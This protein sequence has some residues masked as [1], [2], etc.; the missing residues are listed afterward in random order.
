VSS[1]STRCTVKKTLQIVRET[2]NE[3]IVQVK[4]NQ[5]N[6]VKDLE[7]IVATRAPVAV[8][9]SCD[10]ARNRRE[11]RHVHVY[12]TAAALKG[13]E[14]ETLVAAM[15]CVHRQTLTRSAATGLWTRREEASFYI[16]SVMLPAETFAHAIRGHWGVENKNHWV[17]D[18]TLSEDAS[19][20]RINPGIM[21]R[22]RSQALNIARA[23][24]I[25]NIAAALWNAAIDPKLTL[26]YK[27]L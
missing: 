6:L 13:T 11:D 4:A 27:G 19:R 18:V 1:P 17:R 5:P 26:S 24:G 25:T 20:I 10:R 23:N 15:V 8:H 2:G 12:D 22:L 14:W 9:D 21:A 16:S 3:V 7:Q